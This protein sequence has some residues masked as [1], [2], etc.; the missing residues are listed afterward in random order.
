M[1]F[2][3]LVVV[4]VLGAAFGSFLNVC[5][6]RLPHEKSLLWPESRCGHCLQQI[7]WYDN[8]PLVSYWLL[9][10]RCR[11][12]KTAFS[13][14]YFF[15]ELGTALALVGL[16]YLE[17]RL[18]VLGIPFV[19][20]HKNDFED[21]NLPPWQVWV[22]FVYHATLLCFLIVAALVDLDH[23]EIPL[24]ITLTGT[25]FGVFGSL[26][27][28]WPFP[29]SHVDLPPVQRGGIVANEAFPPG[30]LPWP[31][32]HPLELPTWLPPGSWQLGL[33]TSL[34]GVVAGIVVLR[35]VRLL[36]GVGRGIE[37][38]GIGD[39]D[40]MMMAGSFIG[41][42][43]ILIAL[44]VSVFPGLLFGVLYLIRRGN[45]ALPFGPSLALGILVTLLG[46]QVV[47]DRYRL[48]FFDPLILGALAAAGAVLMLVISFLLR[49]VLRLVGGKAG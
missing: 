14:R 1:L 17:A 5:V 38:L 45:Q 34:A 29:A 47:G 16:F 12:C 40:L 15:V 48:I 8:I 41:W 28:A 3:C 9:G 27:V 2:F 46:W 49:L 11:D 39:A 19:E 26:F 42:Q 25:V 35:V 24:P 22:L 20:A 7:R 30:A 10:G 23:M 21:G 18:N 13:V 6:Y 33:A 37:G 36:F 44:F 4:F 43:P 31:I 32:W